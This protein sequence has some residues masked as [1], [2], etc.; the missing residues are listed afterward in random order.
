[1]V[2]HKSDYLLRLERRREAVLAYAPESHRRRILG[3]AP[4]RYVPPRPLPAPKPVI[5]RRNWSTAPHAGPLVR[6]PQSAVAAVAFAFDVSGDALTTKG[7]QRAIAWPRFALI[8]LLREQGLSYPQIARFVAFN[9]H[10]TAMDGARRAAQ[11]YEDDADW[12]RHFDL[13][14]SMISGIGS[15]ASPPSDT[16]S[17]VSATAPATHHPSAPGRD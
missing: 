2:V 7:G 14:A 17:C 16:S 15:G 6:S 10:T 11:L 1:M 13:A 5:K 8:R 12:R 9:D 3:E 4:I